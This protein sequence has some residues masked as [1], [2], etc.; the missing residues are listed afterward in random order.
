MCFLCFSS[1]SPLV[2]SPFHLSVDSRDPNYL[3]PT[4]LMTLLALSHLYGTVAAG[5]TGQCKVCYTIVHRNSYFPCLRHSSSLCHSI[6]LRQTA[7]PLPSFSAST[8]RPQ[9][10]CNLLSSVLVLF[11]SPSLVIV[12][13]ICSR[14]WHSPCAPHVSVSFSSYT[15]LS[16]PLS[17]LAVS[18]PLLCSLDSDW[19]ICLLYILDRHS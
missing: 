4:P 6:L 10:R 3:S 8:T 7:S 2:Y 15:L 9:L 5:V 14:T 12:L 11:C 16:P 18:C 19:F 13:C 17:S 1:C